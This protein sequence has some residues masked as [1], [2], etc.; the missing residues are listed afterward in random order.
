MKRS[1]L[2]LTFMPFCLSADVPEAKETIDSVTYQ[3]NVNWPQTLNQTEIKLFGQLLTHTKDGRR[4]GFFIDSNATKEEKKMQYKFLKAFL[5]VKQI[6]SN[7]T[8]E[9]KKM[10]CKLLRAFLKVKQHEATSIKKNK[11]V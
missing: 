9:E 1:L 5:K 11:N 4:A 7:A 8:K 3:Q 10:Q 2:L 6:G